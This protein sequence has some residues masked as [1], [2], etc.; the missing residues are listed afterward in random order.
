[1]N[2]SSI[3]RGIIVH[4]VNCQGVMG[5]GIALAIRHRW[6]RVFE[7]YRKHPP[8]LGQIQLVQVSDNL[9]VCN[10]AG[11]E[12]YGRGRRYTNYTAV[13]SGLTK[14]NS[15]AT[16]HNLPVF[17]PAGM[18]CHNAGGDWAVVDRIISKTLTTCNFTIKP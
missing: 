3:H 18:G 6:P 5:C 11:Q 9:Y 15:W 13:Q 16:E 12:R 2:I 17:I 4:Q 7:Q 14:L 10:L 8:S 1:M